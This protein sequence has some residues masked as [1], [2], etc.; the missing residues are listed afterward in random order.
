VTAC[1]GSSAP[2]ATPSAASSPTPTQRPATPAESLAA[3]ARVGQHAAFTATYGLRRERAGSI[4]VEHVYR[5]PP[6]RYRVDIKPRGDRATTLIINGDI[7]IACGPRDGRTQCALIKHVPAGL[8][9]TTLFTS[10]L[11]SLAHRTD[12]YI[13]HAAGKTR[14][15]GRVPAGTCFVVRG[16]KSL[17]RR[18]VFPGV[19]CFS[20]DGIPTK[21]TFSELALT[22]RSLNPNRP[23]VTAF[24]PPAKPE[25]A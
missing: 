18:R 12:A 24:H 25:K 16:G 15:H 5:R 6:L 14:A 11:A 17:D 2:S 23:R 13:V 21:A 4:G 22:L 1:T 3:I 8:N 10:Y 9:P 7:K 20:A 19:Y